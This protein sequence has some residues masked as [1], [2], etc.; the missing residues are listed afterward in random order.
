MVSGFPERL[1]KLQLEA[2]PLEGDLNQLAM[3][4]AKVRFV[5]FIPA[6]EIVIVETMVPVVFDTQAV[7]EQPGLQLVIRLR[8]HATEI[9]VHHQVVKQDAMTS[10]PALTDTRSTPPSAHWLRISDRWK[11]TKSGLAKPL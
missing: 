6:H 10:S 9:E 3:T 1:L 8:H 4:L 11:R 2:G 5:A 7:P